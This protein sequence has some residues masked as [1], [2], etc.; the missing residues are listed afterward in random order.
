MWVEQTQVGCV[1]Y[2]LFVARDTGAKRYFEI[3]LVDCWETFRQAYK[4]VSG[5]ARTVR[6]PS[7]SATPGKVQVLGV[8]E[9]AGERMIALN[10]LQGRDPDWVGR[11]FFAKYDDKASWLDELEPIDGGEFFYEARM[12][13]LLAEEGSP[14]ARPETRILLESAA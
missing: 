14:W 10:F 7:M 2:Y 11:P 13:E 5:L 8:V 12:R 3:P 6:G 1:P 4:H 9:H